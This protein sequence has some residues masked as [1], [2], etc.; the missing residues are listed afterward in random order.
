MKKTIYFDAFSAAFA[1]SDAYRDA[2]T[3]DGLQ[4]LFE[5]IVEIEQAI[6]QEMEFDIVAIASDFSEFECP[7]EAASCEYFTE[8]V[9]FSD[10][11]NGEPLSKGEATQKA[12]AYL[13]ENGILVARLGNGGVLVREI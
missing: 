3:A 7:T 10:K 2:F 5:Y 4:A 11:V 13:E 1:A 6:G 12:L 8:G 9:G